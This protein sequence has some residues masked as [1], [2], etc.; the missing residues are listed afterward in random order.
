MEGMLV[1]EKISLASLSSLVARA[2]QD[3]G[4]DAGPIHKQFGEVRRLVSHR[5]K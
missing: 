4:P 1:I 5:A 2:V 3:V